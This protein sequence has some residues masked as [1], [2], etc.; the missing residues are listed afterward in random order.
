MTLLHAAAMLGRVRDVQLLS[1]AGLNPLTCDAKTVST[2]PSQSFEYSP[3][4]CAAATATGLNVLRHL[5]TAH[6]AKDVLESRSATLGYSTALVAIL[7]GQWD[8]VEWALTEGRG[9]WVDVPDARGMTPTMHLA[10]AIASGAPPRAGLLFH[11]CCTLSETVSAVDD[12]GN[13]ALHHLL[14]RAAADVEGVAAAPLVEN[15]DVADAMYLLCLAGCDPQIANRDSFLATD[16]LNPRDA[17]GVHW[18]H[19]HRKPLSRWSTRRSL[20]GVSVATVAD[21]ANL[22]V[23]AARQALCGVGSVDAKD[24]ITVLP[25]HCWQRA[26]VLIVLVAIAVVAV[27]SGPH[28]LYS[29]VL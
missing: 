26:P 5:C 12:S 2:T 1:A 28:W 25:I 17:Q 13:T 24:R 3:A 4:Q 11:R 9:S 19:L 18:V 20:H 16:L 10:S 15:A 8:T 7:S 29:Q 14:L 21:Q 22:P 23:A 6:A 27:L